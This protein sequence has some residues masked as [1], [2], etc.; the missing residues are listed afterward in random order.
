MTHEEIAE[1]AAWA[2]QVRARGLRHRPRPGG[3]PDCE[4]RPTGTTTNRPVPLVVT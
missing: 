3:A 2:V 1:L 4:A